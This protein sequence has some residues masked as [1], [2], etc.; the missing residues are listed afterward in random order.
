VRSIERI[1]EMKAPPGGQ[2][3][4]TKIVVRYA[5]DS[6]LYFV[7]DASRE[8]FSEDDVLELKKLLDSASSAAEWADVNTDRSL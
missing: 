5:D 4:I 8:A 6:V 3:D 2:G 7:P 1:R